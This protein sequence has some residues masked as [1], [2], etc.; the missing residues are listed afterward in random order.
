M[1]PGKLRIYYRKSKILLIFL[2]LICAFLQGQ[3]D[4]YSKSISIDNPL[5]DVFY[6]Y[7]NDDRETAIN[8]LTSLFDKPENKSSAYINYGFIME[9]EKNFKMAG[10]YY[11]MALDEGDKTAFIYLHNLNK[12]YKPLK[13]LKLLD[14]YFKDE[15][16]YWIDYEKAVYY[17][18]NNQIKSGNFLLR[19][20]IKKGFSSIALL[21]KD[22]VFDPVRNTTTFKRFLIQAGYNI[23]KRKSLLKKLQHKE[24]LHNSKKPYGI[25]RAL[26]IAAY[27][28]KTEEI[29]KA[30][31]ILSSLLNSKIT[32][33]DKN[34]ALFWLARLEAKSGNEHEARNYILKFT[35]HLF[36]KEKDKTG[37]KKLIKKIYKDLIQNDNYLKKL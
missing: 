26:K 35:K 4:V 32:F 5:Y 10:K 23:P 2:I 24:Y 29:E 25:D 6:K 20:A 14:Q 27:M 34:I 28:E 11:T 37:Y 30:K 31:G 16:N 36:S 21:E 18:K 7:F 3:G 17:Y 9:Y 8:L 19:N 15:T 1:K 33:R 12:R 13:S 22:P